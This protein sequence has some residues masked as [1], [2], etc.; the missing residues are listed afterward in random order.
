MAKSPKPH[1]TQRVNHS[2]A[3]GLQAGF[4]SGL[5][6]KNAQHLERLGVPVE[7]ETL[8]VPY[9]IPQK[10][11]HYTPDFPL[12][13]GIIVETK[14]IWDS[15]DRAKHLYVKLQYPELDIRLVFTR[16]K[17][18]IYPGSSTTLGEWADK[19]GFR[20]AEKLIPLEWLK[21]PGPRVKPH[22][23]IAAGPQGYSDVIN[24]KL[25]ARK[26]KAP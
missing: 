13:N 26:V 1:W 11:H 16:A 24:V 2:K 3:K 20:W 17:S 5:E 6:E 10:L 9:V 23:I 14:G 22:D 15:T 12:P 4:R 18:P 8:R 19:H 7:Y 21:E 25:P